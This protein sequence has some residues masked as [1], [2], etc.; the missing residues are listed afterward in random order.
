MRIKTKKGLDIPLMGEPEQ[1]IYDGPQV[2]SV[3]LLGRD[4][5]GLKASLAVNVGDS[6]SLG[7]V[8]FTDKRNPGVKFTSPASGVVESINRGNRRVLQSIVIKVEGRRSEAFIKYAVSKLDGLSHAVVSENLINSGLWTAFRTRPYSKVPAVD[9]KPHSIFVTAMDTHPLSPDANIIINER[10]DDFIHGLQVISKLTEGKVFVC[11][12]PGVMMQVNQ[13]QQ[14]QLTEF[15]GPHPAGVAGTHIHFLDP[16]N[17][18]KT[19]WHI[20]YQAVLAIGALFTTGKINSERV[21]ALSGPEISKPRLIRT[22]SGAST[23]NLVADEINVPE[24]HPDYISR[25]ISGSPLHGHKAVAWAA[26]LGH[27]HNQVTVLQDEKVREF[28]GWI[29]PQASKYSQLNVTLA[30]L[31]INKGY[32]FRMTTSTH[33]SPRAIV[34]VGAFEAVMPLDLHPTPLIKALIVGDTDT[35]LQLGCLELDEE[36]LALCT[37]ADLGKHDF[38]PVLRTNLT[39]IEKEG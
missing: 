22:R 21:V 37:F 39:Q 33:G 9:S 19:V 26:F 11:K 12:A 30:S 28:F 20:G 31:P 7:Q 23:E 34:P 1:V 29:T 27:Y 14:T 15:N 10:A 2:R 13:S 32:K 36:D 17:A 38:G 16:V 5:L 18:N 8:L 6:V 35:A 4:F 25:V 3:A 24:H